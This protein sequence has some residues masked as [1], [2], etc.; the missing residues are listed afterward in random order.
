MIARMYMEFLELEAS[1]FRRLL[2]SN[3]DIKDR[4]VSVAERR[5]SRTPA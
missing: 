1:D 4:I 3:R 5:L 2:E